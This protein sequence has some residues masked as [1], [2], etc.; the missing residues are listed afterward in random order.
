MT[1]PI[2]GSF[3][4]LFLYDV[5]D[6]IRLDDLRGILQVPPAGREP[7]F[8]HPAP[9]YVQ[10]SRPPVVE[11]FHELSWPDG[12]P[13]RGHVAYYEYGVVS[14]KLELPFEGDWQDIIR[15]SAR[16]MNAPELEQK[17]AEAIR[18]HI[19]RA[20][21]LWSILISN[22]SRR[23]ITSFICEPSQTIA[24]VSRLQKI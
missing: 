3:S 5:S 8:R 1:G 16:W 22:A 21:P 14:L 11:S 17:A 24:N 7:P 20:A 10:F 15:L 13:M 18:G 2:S 6:E 19:E 4:I 9:E 23:I 12:E